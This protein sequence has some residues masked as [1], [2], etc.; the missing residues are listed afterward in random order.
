MTSIRR[1]V[2]PLVALSLALVGGATTWLTEAGAAAPSAKPAPPGVQPNGVNFTLHSDGDVNF[3]LEDTPSTS[4]PASETIASQC[5][6]RDNQHWTFADATDGSV[7]IIGGTAGR[8]LDFTGAVP[9]PVSMKPC[10][11]KGTEHFFY[12]ESGQIES[13]SGKKC[14]Q[15]AAAAQNA[16]VSFVK[17]N[18][19]V[20]LQIWIIGH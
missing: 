8:C 1:S 3:C 2:V 9:S 10:T 20:K 13:T 12:S 11:F 4:N 14:L 19:T 7:V 15:T 18:S 16:Q 17:C 6:A 5:A